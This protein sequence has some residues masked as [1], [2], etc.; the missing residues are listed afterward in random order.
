L[1][2][3][4][5]SNHFCLS[6]LQITAAEKWGDGPVGTKTKNHLIAQERNEVVRSY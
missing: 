1:I 2:G 5:A 6:E 3:Y 4:D